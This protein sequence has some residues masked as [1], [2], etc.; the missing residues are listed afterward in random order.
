M[1][2]KIDFFEDLNVPITV[3]AK[4]RAFPVSEKAVDVVHAMVNRLDKNNVTII[5]N[6]PVTKIN[7]ENGKVISIECGEKTFKAE[8]Y[9]LAVGGS[10]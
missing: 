10:S 1:Q 6:N 8:Q 2:D 4:N 7:V 9:I 3:Q 5:K